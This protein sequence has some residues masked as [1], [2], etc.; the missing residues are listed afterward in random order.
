MNRAWSRDGH[1]PVDLVVDA[2]ALNASGI[3][4]YLREVLERLVDDPRFATITLLGDPSQ[5]NSYVYDRGLQA[6]LQLINYPGGFYSVASQMAWLAYRA[7]RVQ[8]RA[9]HFFPH[10]DT[11][12]IGLPTRSVVTIHDLIHFKLPALF[13]VA[14]RVAADVMLRRTVSA[15]ARIIVVSDSAGKDVEARYPSAAQKIRRIHQGVGGNFLREPESPK[16][17]WVERLR[18]FILCVGN[19]KPHKNLRLVV[20][21][22][23]R[24]GD[25]YPDL[26][27]V[28]V[29]RVFADADDLERCA[30]EAGI[31]GRVINLQ[32]VTDEMLCTLYERCLAFVFPSLYEGFGLPALEAMARGAPVLASN[33]AS[34]PEVVG[35]AGVLF[36]PTSAGDLAAALNRL[37]VQPSWAREL[38]LRGRERARRFCWSR[39][40]AETAA[41]LYETGT[42]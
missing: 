30:T 32:V 14:K 26:R 18:P 1:T 2:R 27:L 40:A 22:L 12:L 24:L 21:A 42:C 35:D 6:R 15:A 8:Q 13:P 33:R 10:F 31:A 3:G 7:F 39:T 20:S 29:G 9:V 5:L 37:I 36:D 11:P 34:L 25:A 38:G 28:V 41:T 19:Q 17:P 23:G 4:R 16:V